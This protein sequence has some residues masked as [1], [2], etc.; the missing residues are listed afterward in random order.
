ME[1]RDLLSD[2]MHEWWNNQDVSHKFGISDDEMAVNNANHIARSEAYRNRASMQL[3]ALLEVTSNLCTLDNTGMTPE[4]ASTV[5]RR[6][7]RTNQ[8]DIV[9]SAFKIIA[10]MATVDVGTDARNEDAVNLC[11]DVI[12]GFGD[13]IGFFRI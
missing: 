3:D 11:K 6:L 10:A 7:H 4:V 1:K 13:R 9:R 12:S 5:L 8:A 2:L